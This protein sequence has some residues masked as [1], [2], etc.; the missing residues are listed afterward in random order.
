MRQLWTKWMSLNKEYAGFSPSFCTPCA[1]LAVSSIKGD[2]LK[3]KA[4]QND[5][6]QVQNGYHDLKAWNNPM[7]LHTSLNKTFVSKD[8]TLRKNKIVCVCVYMQYMHI[9]II[10]NITIIH[11]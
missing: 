10:I 11:Y 8:Y 7:V 2:D 5:W 4:Q 1:I 9:Y 3:W 6:A